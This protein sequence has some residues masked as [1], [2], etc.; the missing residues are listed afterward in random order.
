MKCRICL[1]FVAGC[2]FLLLGA[3]VWAAEVPALPTSE[4]IAYVSPIQEGSCLAV[5]VAVPEGQA[6]SGLKWFNGSG[7]YG[8]AQALV[9]SGAE[10]FPPSLTEAV[11]L[12]Q[13]IMGAAEAWSEITF[14]EPVA[15]ASGDLFLILE[16][17]AGYAATD[18]TTPLGVGFA[19]Q[20]GSGCY[21]VTSE[22][23]TW[24]KVASRCQL[25]IEPVFCVQDSTML[26]KSNRPDEERPSEATIPK[27]FAVAAY[28]NPFNPETTIEVSLPKSTHCSIKIYDLRGLLVRE[29]FAGQV[30]AGIAS[31]TWDGKDGRGQ[32]ASSGVY[33]A[34]VKSGEKAINR[35]LVL[36]K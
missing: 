36:I 26:T 29:L 6:V 17:P 20:E 18:S 9:A 19:T 25:L 30:T 4:G 27:V 28:P 35:R 5:K 12:A 2:A 33:H 3:G 10:E 11:G 13:N 1:R 8:F 16:Y 7:D 15:S 23:E 24:I 22:G 32:I 14:S 31:Y 34:L 21:Y